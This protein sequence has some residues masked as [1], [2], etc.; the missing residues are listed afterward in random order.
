MAV[1]EHPHIP[2]RYL[3][4]LGQA[5]VTAQ[6]LKERGLKV[7]SYPF[8]WADTHPSV[9]IPFA[10]INGLSAYWSIPK[11]QWT[12]SGLPRL[13]FVH[14]RL[15]DASDLNYLKRCEK[16]LHFVLGAQKE[17]TLLILTSLYFEKRNIDLISQIRDIIVRSNPRLDFD[18]LSV[19]SQ[20]DPANPG[21]KMY[22]AAP[23][24][25]FADVHSRG[26][27]WGNSGEPRALDD[28]DI[29]DSILGQF[30]YDLVP[31]ANHPIGEIEHVSLESDMR[32]KPYI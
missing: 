19:T 18:I 6:V 7:A 29:W 27:W 3:V 24:I 11:E 17:R 25:I 5:C 28:K 26:A 23:H 4:S 15:E 31:N 30:R 13:E 2:V 16:R 14:H 20:L 1:N 21:L 22:R 12:A 8:D 10:L 32:M 9:A